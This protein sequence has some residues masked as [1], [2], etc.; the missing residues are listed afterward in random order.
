MMQQTFT[1]FSAFKKQNSEEA[2][3]FFEQLLQKLE[4]FPPRNVSY[5]DIDTLTNSVNTQRL[6]NNP[7]RL[8]KDV[9]KDLYIDILEV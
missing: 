7:V 4:I 5:D 8:G 6:H 2:I 9:I 1:D 3:L